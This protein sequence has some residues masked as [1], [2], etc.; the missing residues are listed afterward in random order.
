M[1]RS[2]LIDTIVSLVLIGLLVLVLDPLAAWMPSSMQMAVIAVFV[3]ACGL[4]LA[5]LWRERPRDEREQAHSALAG[6]WAFFTG[7]SVIAIGILWQAM[8]HAVDSWLVVA[9]VGMV[10]AK[11]AARR[12]ADRQ[13]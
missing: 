4:W 11:I 7:S 3:V 1:E 2:A 9:L 6:R 8:Q 10:L 5:L 12:L 13:Q